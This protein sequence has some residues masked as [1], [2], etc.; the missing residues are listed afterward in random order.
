MTGPLRLRL[1]RDDDA[2]ILRS[3]ITDYLQEHLRWWSEA[4]GD[5]PWPNDRIE[6]HLDQ[7]DLVG[8]HWRD[9]QR[10]SG[11][12]DCF[13][14]VACDA[15]RPI[16]VVSAELRQDRYL[17]TPLGVISWIFVDPSSRRQ[18][19]ADRL[20]EAAEGWMTWRDVDG[21]ELF[22]TAANEPALSTYRK[23][24]YRSV[25]LRMLGPP[26]GPRD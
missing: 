16:G 24:G 23:R 13:V 19:I 20:L 14:R 26:P 10:A 1:L 2:E 22:V 3:W 7:H 8:V 17:R 11:S 21:R 4:V 18:G 15:Q 12:A 9:L 6:A 5:G 25:D